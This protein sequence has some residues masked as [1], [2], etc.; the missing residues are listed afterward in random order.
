MFTKNLSIEQQ[1]TAFGVIAILIWSCVA[2]LAIELTSIPPFE[3]LAC[4]ISIAFI[5]TLIRYSF[6]KEKKLFFNF[7]TKDFLIATVALIFNQACYFAAF[8]YSPAVQ[9][10]LINYLWPTMLILLSSFLPKE[11]FCFAYLL[12][13]IVCLWGI[14]NL[15]SPSGSEYF[16]YENIFG[17]LL[18]FG[19]AL[20]WTLYSLYT[21]YRK[22]SSANCISLACALAA[23]LSIIIHFYNEKF[24]IPSIF[25]IFIIFLL[26]ILQMGL[27]FYFWECSIKKGK[28]KVLGL[29]SY[30]IPVLSILILILFNKAE[31]NPQILT[32]TVAIS[33]APVIPLIKNKLKIFQEAR[34]QKIQETSFSK[35]SGKLINRK[36]E[37]LILLRTKKEELRFEKAAR[38][39]A[40][41]KYSFLV[42]GD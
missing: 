42:F 8:R 19:A 11:K 6:S 18:A 3:L 27:A 22:T 34:S 40:H 25:E 20:S 14:Y 36:K 39:L 30:C 41:T 16:S 9:V 23:F 35:A 21:R 2:L 17:Y 31:F 4:Q 24:V 13:C 37:R 28:V 38:N 33:L 5:V 10:D 29:T 12:S 15:L 32:S 1:N 7:S 26:G